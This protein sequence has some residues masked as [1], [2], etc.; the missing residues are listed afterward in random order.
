MEPY[1]GQIELFPYNFAPLNWLVCNGQLLPISGND[2]LFALIGTTY[3]GDGVSTFA[4]PNLNA[5]VP[6]GTG[7][8]QG[9]QPVV[10]G[11][12]AGAEQATLTVQTMPGHT[13]PLIGASNTSSDTPTGLVP[14]ST[15]DSAGADVQMYGTALG[16]QMVA[17]AVTAAGAGVPFGI[18]NPY[19]GMVYCIATQGIFPTAA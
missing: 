5:R 12:A 9:L 18:R 10:L 17:T 13:H 7:T 11:Q 8:G 15:S 6:V 14:A 3:G 19:L 16:G 4:L 2:A 1:I